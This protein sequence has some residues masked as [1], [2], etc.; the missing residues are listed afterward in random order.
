MGDGS[1]AVQRPAYKP[2]LAGKPPEG[3]WLLT[4][5]GRGH[6]TGSDKD[7]V[8]CGSRIGFGLSATSQY[9]ERVY[10]GHLTELGTAVEQGP[11]RST[12]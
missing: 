1:P 5:G 10:S 9:T 12:R 11:V 4:L 2:A 8:L 3:G 7:P 6:P